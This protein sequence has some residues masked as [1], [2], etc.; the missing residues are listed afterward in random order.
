M[1]KPGFCVCVRLV[2]CVYYT[3]DQLSFRDYGLDKSI[4]SEVDF[5]I[6]MTVLFLFLGNRHRSTKD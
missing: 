2:K 4:I 6:L 5:L 3:L 1:C